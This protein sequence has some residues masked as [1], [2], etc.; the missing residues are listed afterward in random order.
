LYLAT[1]PGEELSRRAQNEIYKVEA[2]QEKATKESSRQALAAAAPPQ[3]A[4]EDLLRKMDGRRYTCPIEACSMVIDVRGKV[5]I[6]GNLCPQ[7]H[8]VRDFRGYVEGFRDEIRGRETT[9]PIY[10]QPAHLRVRAV[11]RTY[12][13][14]DDGGSITYRVRYN[15]GHMSQDI[16]LW[17]R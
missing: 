6:M 1:N 10:N 13:I 8:D 5:F 7:N 4:F 17:Q 11:S 12:V 3:N 14:S 9:V 16:F 2:K 15:D